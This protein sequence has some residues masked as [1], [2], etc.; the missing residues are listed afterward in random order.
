MIRLKKYF[1]SLVTLAHFYT[2]P[3]FAVSIDVHFNEMSHFIYQL[4][5]ASGALHALNYT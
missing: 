1:I 4:D 5:R 2:Q 3:L